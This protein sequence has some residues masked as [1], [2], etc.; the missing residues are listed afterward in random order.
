VII[1]STMSS[2]RPLARFVSGTRPRNHRKLL[3]QRL[4]T[5]YIGD[6]RLTYWCTQVKCKRHVEWR[7]LRE[8]DVG[9]CDGL[10]YDQVKVRFP[11]EYRARMQDKLKYRYPRGESYLDVIARLEVRNWTGCGELSGVISSLC[12]R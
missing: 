7:A 10:T 2:K 11:E 12:S 9:I 8:I 6:E 3:L 5:D 4:E 1:L